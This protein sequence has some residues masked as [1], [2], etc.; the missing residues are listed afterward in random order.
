MELP[1]YNIEG[2]A[3]GSVSLSEEI[4]AAPIKEHVVYLAVKHYLANQRQGTHQT[5]TRADVAG[6]TKKPWRQKG[7]GGARAGH[8]RSPLWRHG[9]TIFGP[10]PRDYDSK[11]NHK[12]K[13]LARRSALS[14]KAKDQ[15]IIILQDFSMNSPKTKSFVQIL[16]NLG[17]Q[18]SKVLFV[19][20]HQNAEDAVYL[21][22]RNLPNVSIQRASDL[23]TYEILKS[24]KLIVTQNALNIIHQTF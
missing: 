12:V 10:Q 3:V 13:R 6:S 16:K 5:K 14:A 23:N 22:A 18:Q 19:S 4:F 17:V 11:I 2:K 21:S 1:V 24:Q 7:T 9:G 15:Q 8:K 20:N